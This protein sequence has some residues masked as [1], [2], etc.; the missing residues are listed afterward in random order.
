MT[1][2]VLIHSILGLRPAVAAAAE[3]LRGAG[4]VVHVPDL[5]EGRVFDRIE[6]AA[7]FR[8]TLGHDGIMQ[9]AHAA[10]EALPTA[11]VYAGFSMGAAA[12]QHLAVHRPGARAAILMHQ[13][14]P[15]R[16]VG[17]R[18]PA[19]MP[20]AVH[21]GS[22]DPWVDAAEVDAF[23]DAVRAADGAVDV[24][25]YAGAG[26]MFA[27]RQDPDYDE[28]S[29]ELMWERVLGFLDGRG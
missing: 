3:R 18:W 1:E 15:P 27:D 9:R 2:V 28:Q 4:H 25:A 13:V 20:V 7:A 17:R 12:S 26:H 16:D 14:L 5:W 21:Y 24:H 22:E 10:V 23:A 11:V 29:A 19:A 6:E 8:D